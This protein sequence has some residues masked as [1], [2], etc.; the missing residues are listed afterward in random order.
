MHFLIEFGLLRGGI[1]PFPPP[2]RNTSRARPPP[3][4][5]WLRECSYECDAIHTV[6]P[7]VFHKH[8]SSHSLAV[9]ASQQP[10]VV[11]ISR[12]CNRGSNF[13]AMCNFRDV[14]FL[15]F[16]LRVQFSVVAFVFLSQL[17]IGERSQLRSMLSCCRRR[18]CQ[19]VNLVGP[20]FLW[21]GFD[22]FCNLPHCFTGGTH[23]RALH[24]L[25]VRSGSSLL[26]HIFRGVQHS[27]I[28]L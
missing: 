14:W 28:R 10:I 18:M 16:F 25:T 15:S 2:T 3:Y 22:A 17:H 8:T 26:T 9:P 6:L 12:R 27:W 7:C 20:L 5:A 19:S 13:A 21:P 11:I 1:D 23:I 4:H 24:L